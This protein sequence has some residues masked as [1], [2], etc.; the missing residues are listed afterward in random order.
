MKLLLLLIVIV[1]VTLSLSP[2]GVVP[3]DVTGMDTLAAANE[4]LTLLNSKE[5]TE[6]QLNKILSASVQVVDGLKYVFTV[7]VKTGDRDEIC[8]LTIVKQ[9]WLNFSRLTHSEC[10]ARQV[11]AVEAA[12]S[13][14]VGGAKS[15][16][17]TREDVVAMAENA[18]SKLNA[19]EDTSRTLNKIVSAKIQVVAG[20][21]YVFTTDVQNG[22]VNEVCQLTILVKAWLSEITLTDH[23]CGPKTRRSVIGGLEAVHINDVGLQKSIEFAVHTL[24]AK[25]NSLHMSVPMAISNIKQQIVAG[26]KYEFTM[27][28]VESTCNKEVAI[29]LTSCP[30]LAN[31]LTQTCDV[32]VLFQA[33]TPTQF[34]LLQDKCTAL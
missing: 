34:T 32:Q 5:N 29:S 24:N 1:P 14:V 28:L 11:V 6:R 26:V 31:G 10:K 7:D 27:K 30:Q 13:A 16:D 15:V 25:S 8:R 18:L 3:I 9:A 33:W 21:K 17:T 4:A 19:K 20:I 12:D 23:Q 2:G 22:N